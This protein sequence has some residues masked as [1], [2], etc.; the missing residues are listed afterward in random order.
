MVR[1]LQDPALSQARS[2]VYVKTPGRTHSK[3][4]KRSRKEK[5]KRKI[6]LLLQMRLHGCLGACS[7]ARDVLHR[8]L[9]FH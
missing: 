9:M 4:R 2:Y 7:L 5:I 3:K 1:H 6:H 8:V